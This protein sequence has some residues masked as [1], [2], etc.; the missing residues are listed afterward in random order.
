MTWEIIYVKYT[1]LT[2]VLYTP[3]S[4]VT[5]QIRFCPYF[6]SKHKFTKYGGLTTVKKYLNITYTY[7]IFK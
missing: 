2:K 5:L 6:N 1:F 7:P 3:L 4:S